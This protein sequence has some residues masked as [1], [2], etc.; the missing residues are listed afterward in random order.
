MAE[1]KKPPKYCKTVIP[2]TWPQY[3]GPAYKDGMSVRDA[4]L[5]WSE[6]MRATQTIT[7]NPKVYGNTKVGL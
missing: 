3:T 5:L 4:N 6:F 7:P 2:K 1:H